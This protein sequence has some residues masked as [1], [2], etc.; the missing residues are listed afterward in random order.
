MEGVSQISKKMTTKG[1]RRGETCST[2]Q[3]KCID[4]MALNIFKSDGCI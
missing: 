3:D 1:N 4:R 2:P